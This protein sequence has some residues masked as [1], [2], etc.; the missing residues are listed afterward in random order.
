MFARYA[1]KEATDGS[2]GIAAWRHHHKQLGF[3]FDEVLGFN[4]FITKIADNTARDNKSGI[5][6]RV[7]IGA[8]LSMIDAATDIY[9]I[10]TYYRSGDL[11]L[12]ANAMLAMILTNLVIQI[13]VV[14]A[15]HKRKNTM[16]K[17]KEA[18]ICLLFLRPAVDAYRVGLNTED[19]ETTISRLSE[20]SERAHG[21]E[22]SDEPFEHP[23]GQPLAIFDHPVGGTIK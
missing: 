9:I 20:V 21:E 22:R 12:Q 19:N 11:A 23:Q 3:L 13:L 7:S 8:A 18:L 6:Y 14:L 1:H 5:A 10:A 17:V 4:E 15:Q 16:T 2:A